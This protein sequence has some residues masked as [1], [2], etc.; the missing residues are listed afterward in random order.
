MSEFDN[1]EPQESS[2]TSTSVLEKPK[3]KTGDGD[4]DRFAHYVRKD[5]AN[6][7][8]LTGRPVVALCG[9]VW[10]PLRNANQYPICPRC[11]EIRQ[12][13]IN[14]SNSPFM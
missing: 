1:T 13:L 2:S 9:K 7:S 10:V 4:R 6:R 3:E 5:R 12:Q 11:K 8:A 14:G